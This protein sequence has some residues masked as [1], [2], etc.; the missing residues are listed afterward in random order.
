MNKKNKFFQ[1]TS[2][3]FYVLG[4]LVLFVCLLGNEIG[5]DFIDNNIP[6]F[7]LVVIILLCHHV[8]PP[9]LNIRN[10]RLWAV[11]ASNTLIGIFFNMHGLI[12]ALLTLSYIAFQVLSMQINGRKLL[13]M[14]SSTVADF[15]RKPTIANQIKPLDLFSDILPIIAIVLTFQID[16]TTGLIS[17][18]K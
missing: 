2:A 11:V 8:I 17:V 12:G 10:F 18:F 6:F 14:T 15:M 9:S 7:Y 13:S 16:A 3:I 1:R 5:V 4:F